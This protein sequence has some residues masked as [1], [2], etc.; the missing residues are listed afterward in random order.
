MKKIALLAAL[1]IPAVLV[2][3][4][5]PQTGADQTEDTLAIENPYA[6]QEGDEALDKGIIYFDN[7]SWDDTTHIL[8]VSGNLPN[9][10]SQLRAT[11]SQG[12]QQIDLTIYSV[13]EPEVMCAQMLQPFEAAFKMESFD[14]Q[15]FR[16]FING[17]EIPL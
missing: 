10:C 8:N 6:P 12:G 16:V 5:A 2:S 15:T 13:S 11:I 14:P 9:P 4:A 17:Q 3:C 7:A 1:I